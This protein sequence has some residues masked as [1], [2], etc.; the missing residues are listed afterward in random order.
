MSY[1]SSFLNEAAA[2]GFFYQSTNLEAMDE[3][4]VTKGR[5][6]YLGIDVTAKS[7]HVGHMIPIFLLRLFQK[8]GHRPIVLAGGG[9]TKIGDPSFKN[10][11]RP[12]L[13]DEEIAANMEGIKSCL[14]PLLQFGEGNS[15]AIMVNNADWLDE[16]SYIPFLRDIGKYF[17]INRMIGF[18]S[19][20][21]K[22]DANNSLSFLE[23]NYMVL[24][25]YDFYKLY[26][27]KECR[28]QFGGQDQWGNIVC[29]VELL[30]KKLGKE[31]FG[32]T[33]PLLTTSNGQKMG[34]TANG[35]VWLSSELLSS[36]D[37]WQYWRNVDDADVIKLM[38][39]FT[40]VS[41]DEIKKMESIQGQ[42]L[43]E[44]KKMLADEVTTI[45]HGKDCLAEIHKAA[46]SMF[47][48]SKNLGDED[49]D[50]SS[51][52]SIPKYYLQKGAEPVSV[53]DILVECNMCSSRGEAKRLLRSNAVC[54]N[55]K[56]IAEDHK[57]SSSSS[58]NAAQKLSC[59]KKK[60]LLILES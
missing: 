26:I 49:N 8:H 27:D 38:Y 7:L 23:F 37:F 52:T 14:R 50:S 45:V 36:Y 34:K 24:Q 12:M 10:T 51:L 59:G 13:T 60:H 31:V 22:L 18:E 32:F 20:K 28:I 16:L 57:V 1:K 6:G 17:S 4:L 9:T 30:K 46:G 55:G 43:N 19:V 42:E 3:F 5:F 48:N 40:D 54:L 41:V 58:P 11:T 35:A 44:I 56:T 33:N 2:R 15:D 47:G 29:G 21:A 39:L 53:V 25:A